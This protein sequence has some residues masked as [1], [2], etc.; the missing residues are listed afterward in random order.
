MGKGLEE[1]ALKKKKKKN[2]EPS[3]GPASHV[4]RV[5]LPRACPEVGM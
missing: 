5:G 4:F 3:L 1:T 2:H